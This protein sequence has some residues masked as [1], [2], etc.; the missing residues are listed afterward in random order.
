MLVAHNHA[1]DWRLAPP[2]HDIIL[3]SRTPA[4]STPLPYDIAFSYLHTPLLLVVAVNTAFQ[5]GKR[6]V[7]RR[8]HLRTLLSLLGWRCGGH[9]VLR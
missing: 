6:D 9:T 3:P 5:H 4:C 2:P 8:L 7:W 1:F